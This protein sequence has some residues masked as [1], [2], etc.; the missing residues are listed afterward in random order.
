MRTKMIR[1][2]GQA[3][4]ISALLVLPA[5]ATN[6]HRSGASM[7]IQTGRVVGARAV[8]LQSQA[9]RATPFLAPRPA[10]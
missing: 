2:F 9:G 6:G 3:V 4:L 5:C 10:V 1:R 8:D 7:T